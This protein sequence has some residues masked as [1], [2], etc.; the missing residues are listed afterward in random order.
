MLLAL[1]PGLAATAE[2]RGPDAR[3]RHVRSWA[4]AIGDGGLAG[5]PAALARRY[6]AYDLLVV[7]GEGA[8]RAQ[9]RALRRGGRI[10]LAYLDVGAV[11]SGRSWFQRAKPY[12]LGF[13][14]DWGE[15]YADTSAAGYRRLIARAVAP[16]MLRKGFDGLFLDNTDM[17][18][19]HPRQAAGMRSLVRSLA[20]LVHRRHGLLFAQNGEEVVRPILRYVDGWNR[21]D[22]TRTY[23]F[24]RRRYV[25]VPP[26]DAAAARRALRMVARA[27]VFTTAT[28]YVR[29]GDARDTARSVANA[30]GAGALPF[31]SDIELTRV[32]R[33]PVACPR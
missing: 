31:V 21:E 27:G 2:A 32:P 18:S 4:F 20:A 25:A 3:L 6:A 30:C 17:I 8:S 28:D 24:S 13:W 5:S 12:R 1:V 9:I 10:V 16:P 19:D 29:P 11:E 33:R 7:D 26:A 15:W 22:V 14:G 23:S